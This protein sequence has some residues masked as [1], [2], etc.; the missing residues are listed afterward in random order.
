NLEHVERLVDNQLVDMVWTD[1]PYNVDYEGKTKASLKIDNDSM[2][3]SQFRQFLRDLFTS[4]FTVTKEGGP[5]YVAHADTEGVNF[6]LALQEA[7]FYLK[8]VLIWVKSSS[9]MGRQDYHWQ[10]EPILYGWKPGAA[11][12]WY[13]ERNKK[14]VLDEEPKTKDL[15]KN[16]L[17]QEVKEL[18]N[19]LCGT[20]IREDKPNASREHPT[21]KPVDLIIS[22]VRNSSKRGDSVLD[23][24]GGSG[25]TLIACEKLGRSSRVMELDPHYCD[26]IIR[27]WQKFTGQDAVLESSGQTF[28]L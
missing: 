7:G 2:G 23:L 5:I 9:V 4:A 26:V 15:D 11:H 22:M 12:V 18:R 6:R 14:T 13:G 1:P 24:C 28:G 19:R 8:Q 20:V 10:H 16:A 27:R 21:M 25:S 3:D 17:A